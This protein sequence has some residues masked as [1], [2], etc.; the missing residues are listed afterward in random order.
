MTACGKVLMLVARV[1]LMLPLAASSGGM[2]LLELWSSE[3]HTSSRPCFVEDGQ[4]GSLHK[5]SSLESTAEEFVWDEDWAKN[6]QQPALV[7]WLPCLSTHEETLL[8]ANHRCLRLEL[9][10]RWQNLTMAHWQHVIFGDES[11]F[12]LYLVDVRLS[13]R[14]LP[15]ARFRQRCQAYRLQACSGLVHVCG[16]CHSGAKSPLV[17]RDR[18]FTG[19]LYRGIFGMNWAVQSSVWATRPRILVNSAK[20]CRMNGQKSL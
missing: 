12:Q 5:C 7:P 3:D 11:R 15:C 16:V 10:Q 1:R 9:S 4:T 2:L 14:R 8:T 18:Y 17:L 13:V 6:H 20:P 19:E